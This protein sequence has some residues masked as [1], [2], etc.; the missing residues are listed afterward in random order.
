MLSEVL[1]VSKVLLV[2][3]YSVLYRGIGVGGVLYF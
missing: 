1:T 3:K 2:G